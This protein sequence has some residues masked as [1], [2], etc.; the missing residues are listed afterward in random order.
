MT[1]S[2]GAPTPYPVSSQDAA[3]LRDRDQD[4]AGIEAHDSRCCGGWLNA[5]TAERLTPCPTCRPHLFPFN[6]RHP[7]TFRGRGGGGHG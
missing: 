6:D 3:E 7:V 4:D 1:R 2:H 5:D